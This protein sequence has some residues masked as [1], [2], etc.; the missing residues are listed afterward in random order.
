MLPIHF[1]FMFTDV[2]MHVDE[3]KQVDVLNI[4]LNNDIYIG[5]IYQLY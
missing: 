2:M 4:S 1:V 3:Q 5:S